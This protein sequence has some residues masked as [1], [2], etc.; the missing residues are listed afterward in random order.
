MRLSIISSVVVSA[1]AL[2]ACGGDDNNNN[3]TTKPAAKD[4]SFAVT[5]LNTENATVFLDA[6]KDGKFDAE[7]EVSVKTNKDGVASFKKDAKGKDLTAET[8]VAL[9][10]LAIVAN[11]VA[12]ESKVNGQL[13]LDGY[14][15]SSGQFNAVVSSLTTFVNAYATDKKIAVDAA[16]T[17]LKET[18]LGK[19]SEVSLLVDPAKQ[20]EEK[21]EASK[22]AAEAVEAA[23]KE[24]EAAKEAKAAADKALAE[25][26]E[27][28]DKKALEKAVA[29]AKTALETA[30]KD[31]KEKN[32]AKSKA[33][34]TKAAAEKVFSIARNLVLFSDVDA[35]KIAKA[36][37]DV[38]AEQADDFTKLAVKVT[39]TTATDADGKETKTKAYTAEVVDNKSAAAFIKT[40]AVFALG[41]DKLEAVEAAAKFSQNLNE[42]KKGLTEA[43]AETVEV[44]KEIARL[45]HTFS[46]TTDGASEAGR[47][48]QIEALNAGYEYTAAEGEDPAQV[49]LTEEGALVVTYAFTTKK[50]AEKDVSIVVVTPAR[51]DAEEVSYVYTAKKAAVAAQDAKPAEGDKE[52]VPAKEAQAAQPATVALSKTENA[53][54]KRTE[55]SATVAV[56]TS[57]P[58]AEAEKATSQV[59]LSQ[60]K[61]TV[62]TVTPAAAPAEKETVKL[63]SEKTLVAKASEKYATAA[64]TIPAEE[65][66]ERYVA[67]TITKKLAN[68]DIE[69]ISKEVKFN[70]FEQNALETS[71]IDTDV[72]TVKT[73][74]TTVS[75]ATF[76]TA[77]KADEED[78]KK[79]ITTYSFGEFSLSNA[80]YAVSF[81]S[82]E[83]SAEDKKVVAGEYG[84]V[85]V[86]GQKAATIRINE[87]SVDYYVDFANDSGVALFRE[88]P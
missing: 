55:L 56:Y 25:A 4:H 24:V 17:K 69:F 73:L 35:S 49:T 31:H 14:T 57:E 19:E 87:T 23:A 41:Q 62:S 47:K 80:A 78:A 10:K 48:A 71:V 51:R 36:I 32:T 84:Q 40:N 29:D 45:V 21:A 26:K 39:E 7:K 77:T 27:G 64:M 83:L 12:G 5:V 44:A 6:D 76:S 74:E 79:T 67:E 75:H 63:V 42:N 1:L 81:K 72:D 15:L 88:R 18:Y 60:A 34:S 22:K 28:D 38:T 61:V 52:A 2:T 50:V 68:G 20:L 58:K 33:A 46:T 53:G 66:A 13:S 86:A 3:S 43:E 30:E 70:S 9:Q 37:A 59:M 16:E 65:T 54:T 82:P 8:K 85:D 11:V